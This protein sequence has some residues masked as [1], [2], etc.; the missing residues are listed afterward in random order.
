M[1][2]RQL[3]VA[4]VVVIQFICFQIV[5]ELSARALKKLIALNKISKLVARESEKNFKRE[6]IERQLDGR[7]EFDC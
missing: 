6:A 4:V 2:S 3:F 1:K 7:I 5:S